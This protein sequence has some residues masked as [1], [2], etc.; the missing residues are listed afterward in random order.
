MTPLD[1]ALDYIGGQ[2][3]VFPCRNADEETGRYDPKTGEFEVLKAKSPLVSNGFRG[4]T[5][6]ERVARELWKRYPQAM[7]GIPTGIKTGVWVLDVDKKTLDDGSVIDGFEWLDAMQ[8]EHGALPE[9]SIVTTP[10]GGKH[11]YWRYADGVKNRGDIGRGVDVRG[12]GGFVIAAG[13]VMADG[14]AYSDDDP[15]APIVEAPQW[16]LD[17]VMPPEREDFGPSSEY[18]YR[19]GA[20]E[21]YVNAAVEAEMNKLANT[22]QGG[23]GYQLNASAFSLGQLVGAGALSRGDAEAELFRA[24]QANGVLAADGEPET[25]RK[26]KRGLDSGEK[27]PRRIPERGTHQEDNTRLVDVTRMIENGRRKAAAAQEN[28][29]ERISAPDTHER[30]SAPEREPEA[31][32][33]PIEPVQD[34]PK[35]PKQFAATPFNWID[36]KILPRRSFAFGV[37]YIRKYVSVTVAPGGLGKTANSIVDTLSMTSGR[38]LA[39]T[40]PKDRLRV[41]LFNAED[42]RDELERR[43]MA[44]C[45]HYRLKPDD[46][47][48]WLFLDTGREQEMVIAHDDKKGVKINE[49][50]VEAVVAQILQ[51]QIDVMIVDPF[52]STHGVNENDNGAIDK[53][54]KLWAHIADR[55]NCSI[56]IVHHL[57]K[58]QDGR[59]STVEDARGAV[60]LIGAARSV[61][62]LN[63][64]SEDQAVAAGLNPMDRFGFFS[65]TYGKSNLTPLTHKADWRHLVGQALGNGGDGNLGFSKQDHAPVVTEFKWPGTEEIVGS[66]TEEQTRHIKTQLDNG[67]FK[68]AANA[69]AWA[70]V[71]VAYALGLDIDDKGCRSR[72]T[73]VLRAMLKEGALVEVR[74]RDPI[75]RKDAVFIRSAEYQARVAA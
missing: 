7:V 62:V 17:L 3:P 29:Q 36:P 61:R 59:E 9:T 12:E 26:I 73:G 71:A 46:I 68:P 67:D 31:T 51:N 34:Q 18:T 45:L 14:R 63:R 65:I 38:P 28:T 56:D 23:R 69:K 52:V 8:E 75:S 30:I 72:V 33:T 16:L 50:I 70:G 20:H 42:P 55:T 53:V 25:R 48:G 10:R 15:A 21:P 13:S 24:A 37:H 49:P 39:G 47:N 11:Y 2:W 43:I 6:S 40:K 57:R 19:P 66:L 4:A 60:S 22:G 41:W 35:Q 32:P 64:M 44:A 74:E 58:Q 1:L 5:L 27:E 54:A